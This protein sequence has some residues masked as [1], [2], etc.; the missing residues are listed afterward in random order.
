MYNKFGELAEKL[1]GTLKSEFAV[2]VSTLMSGSVISQIIPFLVSPIVAR[3]YSPKDY[4]IVAAYNSITV[5][6]TIVATGMYSSA[7][8]IDKTD[9][10]AINTGVAAFIITALITL[11]SLFIFVLFTDGIAK[12]TGNENITFWLYLIPLTVFFTGGYQTLNMWNN[13]K[14][15]YMRLAGN[16]IFQ[17]IITS[18]ATLLFGFL[19]Y[20][21]TGLMVSLLLGQILAFSLLFLQTLK[22]DRSYLSIVSYYSVKSSF[23]K[24]KDF[25]KYN[26]PTGFLDGFRESS[27]VLI[28]SNYFGSVVL[29]SYSFAMGMINKPFQFIG[30]SFRQVFYQ[31]ISLYSQKGS[32]IL[33]IT[34]KTIMVLILT[35]V[36][37]LFIGTVFGK[38]IFIIVFSE[39]WAQAGSFVQILLVWVI[40]RFILSSISSIPL[41]INELKKNFLFS[42]LYNF[43]PPFVLFIASNFIKSFSTIL[44]FFALANLIVIFITFIWF[45]TILKKDI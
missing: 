45:I 39:K 44:I 11:L 36:I 28:I 3:L 40:F 24:H 9:E 37:P 19:S 32:K 41:A 29:G 31:K 23:K 5:L 10:E 2:N 30:D 26:M 35:M 15:K 20:H 4:A 16:R 27:I 13:R 38:D 8:M 34:K 25:L 14:K 21:S 1:K 42:L 6:L 33:E 18:G 7:L 43:F 12:L 17:T 22:D